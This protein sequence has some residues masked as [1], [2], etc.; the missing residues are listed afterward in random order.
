MARSHIAVALGAALVALVVILQLCN[1]LGVPTVDFW[2]WKLVPQDGSNIQQTHLFNVNDAA[3]DA[4]SANASQYLLG[5]G[6]ADI[7]G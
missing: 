1:S 6:K 7:T 3:G 4:A 2:H 5:V